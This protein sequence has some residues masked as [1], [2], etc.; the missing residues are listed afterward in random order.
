MS[1]AALHVPV[2]PHA[3]KPQEEVR[4]FASIGL[5][6]PKN[7]FNVGG[8]MRAAGCYGASLVAVSGDRYRR[9]HTDTQAVYRHLPVVNCDS[10]ESIRPVGAVAVA[11]DLVP[12]ATPL[13]SYVHPE[14]AFYIFGPEDGTLGPEILKWCRD[15]IYV[16][17][18]QCMNLACT[19]NVVLYDRL[20]KRGLRAVNWKMEKRLREEEVLPST[21]EATK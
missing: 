19:V 20:L 8:V 15:R 10:L 18:R 21:P 6:L 14:S 7:R 13:P 12:R 11:V 17:T 5:H 16:P 9:T 3:V 1:D 2:H 4:G